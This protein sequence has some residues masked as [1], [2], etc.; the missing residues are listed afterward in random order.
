[1]NTL[2]I[3]DVYE[4]FETAEEKKQRTAKQNNSM[5][6]YIRLV[7]AELRK[8]KV[9]MRD[10]VSGPILADEDIVKEKIWKKI[11]HD[12]YGKDSTTDQTTKETVEI[13][14]TLNKFFAEGVGGKCDPFHIPWPSD[15][16]PMVGE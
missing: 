6:K 10:F 11:L 16:P 3:D 12:V 5:H 1:M 15:E 4:Q 9:D 13:Y 8:Q 7:V 2:E 14:E